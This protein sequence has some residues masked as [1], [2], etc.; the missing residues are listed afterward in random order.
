MA[1]QKSHK[2]ETHKVESGPRA[3]ISVHPRAARMQRLGTYDLQAPGQHVVSQME[4]TAASEKASKVL[5]KERETAE[6]KAPTIA[7]EV[8]SGRKNNMIDTVRGDVLKQDEIQKENAKVKSKSQE[9]R[10]AAI[11]AAKSNPADT[12]GKK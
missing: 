9:R 7:P 2:T 5:A 11:K 3:A 6:I 1:A 10:E 8:V 12:K 4:I